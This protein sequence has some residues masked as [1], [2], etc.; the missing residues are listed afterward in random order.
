M[1]IRRPSLEVVCPPQPVA[2]LLPE[3]TRSFNELFYSPP[4]GSVP[5]LALTFNISN[6]LHTKEDPQVEE[7]FKCFHV[8]N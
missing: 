8:Y 4:P 2:Y 1:T 3:E 6:H 5:L 7:E